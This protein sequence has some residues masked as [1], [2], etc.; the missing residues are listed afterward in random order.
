MEKSKVDENFDEDVK[1]FEDQPLHVI[2]KKKSINLHKILTS[3]NNRIV[4]LLCIR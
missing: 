2:H 3:L 1:E 4:F